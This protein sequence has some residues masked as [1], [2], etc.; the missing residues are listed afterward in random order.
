MPVLFDVKPAVAVR[1]KVTDFD[2]KPTTGRFPFTDASGHVY[3]PQAKRL[4]PD[5]FFQKQIYRHDGGTILLPP[6]EVHVRV[7]PRSGVPR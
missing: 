5:F 4:A 7:R 2:G 3:P 1:V 6:G